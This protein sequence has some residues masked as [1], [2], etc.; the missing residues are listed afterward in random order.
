MQVNRTWEYIDPERAPGRL[1]TYGY[2]EGTRIH[3]WIHDEFL[4]ALTTYNPVYE[5]W[6]KPAT[7]SPLQTHLLQETEA[8][9][10]PSYRHL[11][12]FL[13]GNLFVSDNDL[14][15][16]AMPRRR[17]GSGHARVPVP[18]TVPDLRF[19]HPSEGVVEVH[20]RDETTLHKAR[21]RGV[22]GIELLWGLLDHEPAT[23]DE[24]PRSAFDTRTP[25]RFSFD[26]EDIGKHLYIYAR[27]ENTRGEK[28]PWSTLYRALIS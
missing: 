27:W 19:E 9:L 25:Y 24:L 4:T 11:F 16:M 7:R 6:E 5:A 26:L 23:R 18:A 8:A 14:E 20:F 10:K 28:G 17:A 15:A 22:H 3:D 2:P 21:P 1:A 13:R 12:A